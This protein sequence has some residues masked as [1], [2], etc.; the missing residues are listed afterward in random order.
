MKKRLIIAGFFVPFYLSIIFID[1]LLPLFHLFVLAVSMNIL[2]EILHMAGIDK[3]DH[4]RV[5]VASEIF[6]VIA[7]IVT[8]C[9]KPLFTDLDLTP[10]Y[11]I[12]AYEYQYMTFAMGLSIALITI[13]FVINIFEKDEDYNTRRTAIYTSLF[14]FTYAG[15]CFWHF[16]LLKMAPLGK[17]DIIIVHLCAW[18]ADTGGYVVGR[19]LGKHKL[20]NTPSPNKSIEGFFGMFLFTIPV[21]LILHYFASNGHLVFLIGEARPHYTYLTMMVLTVIFTITGFLGDMAE[22]LIKRAYKKK[23]S[24]KWLLNYGG[25]FD[26]FDSVILTMPIAYYIFILLSYNM[27]LF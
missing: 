22:S 8:V 19:K 24:G 2:W 14:A 1:A 23:D 25:V 17:Y 13:L 12:D 26:V 3:C 7:Y 18:L 20:K 9:G 21:I 11:R 27:D 4:G 5:I 15:I 6:M 10:L 16:S